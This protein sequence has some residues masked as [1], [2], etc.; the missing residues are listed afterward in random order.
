MKKEVLKLECAFVGLIAAS[1]AS[2]AGITR[3]E[4]QAMKD[5]FAPIVQVDGETKQLTI[6]P[7]IEPGTGGLVVGYRVP[8]RK[9]VF[10]GGTVQTLDDSTQALFDPVITNA[11]GFTDSGTPSNFTFALGANLI[12]PI[13]TVAVGSLSISGS[14]AD[15]AA[16][17]GGATPFATSLIAQATIEGA[18]VADA[19]PTAVFS[20]PSDVY[21]PYTV[22]YNFDCTTLGD[23]QCD[24]FDLQV[25]FTGSGG[26]D[27]ISFTA[28]HEINPIPVPPAVWLFGSGLLGMVGIA[29][30]RNA[31]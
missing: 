6:V 29:R 18:G 3:A 16:D 10:D 22:N 9:Y 19:G 13:T 30:R 24:S 28:R 20:S 21:G 4:F 8:R 11:V 12:P 26:D 2:A 7:I 31:A 27:A 25:S 15:G 1:S 23:G 17:G 14:F 5:D